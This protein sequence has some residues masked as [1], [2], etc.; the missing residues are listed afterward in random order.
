MQTHLVGLRLEYREGRAQAAAH[1]H[2]L[3]GVVE[4]P[5]QCCDRWRSAGEGGVWIRD[6]TTWR[7][8]LFTPFR[9]PKGPQADCRFYH[10]RHTEGIDRCGGNF[11]I[12][13]DLS[14]D[15]NAHKTLSGDWRGKTTFWLQDN[16]AA[17]E[18]PG[19]HPRHNHN[20]G[21]N[22]DM[23]TSDRIRSMNEK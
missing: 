11:S 15:E 20:H 12:L 14:V 9:V 5:R 4:G 23:T 21:H 13:D 16:D 3:G 17:G 1:L 8:S 18:F 22:H 10:L 2:S 7:R 6:H 19:Q